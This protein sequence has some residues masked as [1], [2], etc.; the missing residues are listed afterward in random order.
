MDVADLAEVDPDETRSLSVISEEESDIDRTEQPR[1]PTQLPSEAHEA[2]TQHPPDSKPRPDHQFE[3][4]DQTAW[5]DF[6]FDANNRAEL[7]KLFKTMEKSWTGTI[8]NVLESTPND[9]KDD[10][11]YFIME[12]SRREPAEAQG[13]K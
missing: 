7:G 11:D 2:D 5:T 3:K 4:S 10:L 12:V 8:S 13:H 1:G 6:E 9:K